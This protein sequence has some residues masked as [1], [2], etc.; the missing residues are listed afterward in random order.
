VLPRQGGL[1][2]NERAV[3][4]FIHREKNRVLIPPIKH[5]TMTHHPR[6]TTELKVDYLLAL[7]K[8]FTHRDLDIN[9][10][11]K[12]FW[13]RQLNPPLPYEHSE[14]L[15][16]RFNHRQSHRRRV[17]TRQ[18]VSLAEDFPAQECL[19]NPGPVAKVRDEFMK[20]EH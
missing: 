3:L 13:L 12:V 4:N 1:G 9:A 6:S 15:A 19:E 5:I 10:R 7:A 2:E 11:S 16:R 20:K 8:T 14:T 17:E 18:V